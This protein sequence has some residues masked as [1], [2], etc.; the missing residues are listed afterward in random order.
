MA[1]RAMAGN[2]DLHVTS[3]GVSSRRSVAAALPL[4]RRDVV[5][6]HHR[7]V[8]DPAEIQASSSVKRQKV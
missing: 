8:T 7:R 2:P 4:A 1:G 6:L 5:T 3:E